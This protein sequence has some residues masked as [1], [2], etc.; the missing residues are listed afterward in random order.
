[1]KIR[2]LIAL[3][4][5]GI[6]SIVQAQNRQEDTSSVYRSLI[7]HGKQELLK[8]VDIIA[9]MQM[10]F[11]SDFLDG[12]HQISKFQI[13][14][15]RL[16]I[17]GYVHEKVYFRFRH[18]Y[19][20]TF[21]PQSIDKIIK[22]VDFAYVRFDISDKLQLTVGK[23]FADWGGIEFDLNPIMI[24]EYSDIIEN[25]DNFLTGVGLYHQTTKNHGFSFQILNSR[26]GS[27]EEI[28]DTVPN[29]VSS[30][31]ALAGV[32]NW[33]GSFWD[34]KFTT[35]WSYSLFNEAKGVFK[36]Y[37]AFGNQLKLNK[38]TLAYDYLWSKEDLDRTGIISREVPDDIYN[39]ALENTLYTSHWFKIDYRF[40]PKWQIS[41]VGF[42]DQAKWLDDLDPTKDTDD[43]RTAYGFIP[44]LEYFPWD[45]INLKFYAGYVGRIY[46]YSDY[47][48]S[49]VGVKDY[50]T[51]RL[52]IGI[53]SP[54]QVL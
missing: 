50:N 9:N 5:L 29:L 36:N 1:M 25:A 49:R 31:A 53:I 52:I 45:D 26:T 18:R 4:S 23:T 11:R 8:N 15:F 47:A 42:I 44:T 17:K 7:P 39:Y 27:F 22:G 6:A 38:V 40:K 12:N 43:W 32:I 16:E 2:L 10:G 51:G 46:N 28:Y 20:S 14:Q 48:K 19:T 24:Y 33:R 35:L 21:E 37:L 3:I 13:E 41:F 54:M 30:K 34:G